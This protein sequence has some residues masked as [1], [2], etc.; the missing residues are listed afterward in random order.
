MEKVYLGLGTNLG[1]REETLEKAIHNL[2][3]NSNIEILKISAV[4]ETEAY[5][6]KDQPDFLNL[7][8]EAKTSL[9]PERLLI[10]AKSI[11]EQMGRKSRRHWGPREIDVDILAYENSVVCEDFLRVPHKELSKRRFVL[12]PF[13][14]IASAFIPPDRNKSVRE[15]LTLCLDTGRVRFYKHLSIEKRITEETA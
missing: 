8:L 9:S 3:L 13:A 12:V 7:V 10:A 1:Q 11:E 2:S 14:E 4:Y 5:G 15:L 6:F